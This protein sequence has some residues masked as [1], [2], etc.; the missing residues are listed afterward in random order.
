VE[1]DWRGAV[2]DSDDGQRASR[3]TPDVLILP[4]ILMVIILR[5]VILLRNINGDVNNNIAVKE[6][7]FMVFILVTMML[8][9]HISND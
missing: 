5:L 7:M 9:V 8:I 3:M 6:A 2:G 1:C 4:G